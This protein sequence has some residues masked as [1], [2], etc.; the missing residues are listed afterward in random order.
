MSPA[1]FQTVSPSQ[2]Q[3]Q[4]KVRIWDRLD[5][6]TLYPCDKSSIPD[7]FLPSPLFSLE[8]NR[9]LFVLEHS[10]ARLEVLSFCLSPFIHFQEF[11]NFRAWFVAEMIQ[12]GEGRPQ[13]ISINSA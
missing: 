2:R 10:T 5:F 9:Y 6:T 11:L 7:D 3:S 12:M 13:P 8:R 4:L 1:K